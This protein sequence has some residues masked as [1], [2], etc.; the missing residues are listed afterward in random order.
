MNSKID[1][2]NALPGS[3]R[4]FLKGAAVVGL[5]IGFQWSGARRALA[6]ALPDAGFA[7]NAF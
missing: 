4:G 2:S 6:A 3:R 1:L 7:P 5:T